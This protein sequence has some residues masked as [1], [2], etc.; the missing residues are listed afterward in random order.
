VTRK[1]SLG[2]QPVICTEGQSKDTGPST[3][4]RGKRL[5]V[6]M[7]RIVMCKVA[8]TSQ[9]KLPGPNGTKTNMA[10]FA[11]YQ[12]LK[13]FDNRLLPVGP[14]YGRN[15]ELLPTSRLDRTNSAVEPSWLPIPDCL[16]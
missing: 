9:T 7:R 16:T 8:T 10:D 15:R 1:L 11:A 4:R 6:S 2:A 5:C 3:K 12:E 13:Q 14:S